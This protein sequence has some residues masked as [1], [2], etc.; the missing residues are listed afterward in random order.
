MESGHTP[1]RNYP[2]Y[3]DGGVP[4]ISI[5]D[6]REAHGRE[7]HATTQTVSELGLANS[8][9]R[10]LPAKTVCLSRTASVGYVTTMGKPMATSQDFADWICTPA[11]LPEFL[12]FAL[13]AEGEHIRTFGEGSSA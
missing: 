8:S 3:W 11:L 6:A 9:A 4:W 10:L 7:I 13:L 1:S 5:P 2:D 12:M